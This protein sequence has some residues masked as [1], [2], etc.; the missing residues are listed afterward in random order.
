MTHKSFIA[1]AAPNGS[2]AK[3]LAITDGRSDVRRQHSRIRS[4]LVSCIINVF[5]DWQGG[6]ILHVPCRS[7]LLPL[8][9]SPRH[10]VPS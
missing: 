2:A 8:L 4:V 9:L 5:T 6:S 1:T 3:N 7:R 10:S